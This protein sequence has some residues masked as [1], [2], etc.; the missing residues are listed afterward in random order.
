MT[1][2]LDLFE[3]EIV[4]IALHGWTKWVLLIKLVI[5]VCLPH[6]ETAAL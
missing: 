6:Q 5:K 2:H 1:D 3:A 4:E